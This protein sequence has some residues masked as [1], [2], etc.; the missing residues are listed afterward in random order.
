MAIIES[1]NPM[2]T[3]EA[4][5]SMGVSVQRMRVLARGGRVAAHKIGHRW[6]IEEIPPG[7]RRESG[8]PLSSGVAWAAL[9]ILCGE[10][11][12]WIDPTAR[13]RLRRRMRDI[14]WLIRALGSS[15]ARATIERLRVLPSDLSKLPSEVR[16]VPSGLSAITKE[17]DI[18]PGYEGI[19]A[20]ISPEGLRRVKRRFKPTAAKRE[21]NLILRVPTVT[22]ILGSDR[23]PIAIVA[24]DLLDSEDPRV[25]RAGKDVLRGLRDG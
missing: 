9:A 19:D 17:F 7:R 21:S 5:K 1:M 14:D 12:R 16:I 6:V 2:S 24:A 22:W 10:K 18:V 25:S 3:G 8:R 20:Y 23:A 13:S 15:Q 4:A 11:P